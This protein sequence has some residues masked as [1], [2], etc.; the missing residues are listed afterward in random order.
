MGRKLFEGVNFVRRWRNWKALRLDEVFGRNR[1]PPSSVQKSWR[2]S[3]DRQRNRRAPIWNFDGVT[4]SRSNLDQWWCRFHPALTPPGRCPFRLTFPPV[5]PSQH[6]DLG[7]TSGAT[8]GA[9]SRRFMLRRTC[10]APVWNFRGITSSPCSNLDHWWCRRKP[11]NF[12][13]RR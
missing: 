11:E 2:S 7:S 3:L 8:W 13:V 12:N 5:T 10:P 6:I 9:L 4:F 1:P